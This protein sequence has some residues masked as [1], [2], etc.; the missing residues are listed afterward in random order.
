MTDLYRWQEEALDAL[1]QTMGAGG[2]GATI[3][4]VTGAGKTRVA[5][6]FARRL[7]MQAREEEG[8]PWF[9]TVVVPRKS[10]MLQWRDDLHDMFNRSRF[11]GRFGGGGI[12]GWD[13]KPKPFWNI[14][15]INAMRDGKASEWLS[16]IKE[17]RNHL[18][19]VD[20][21]HNITAPKNRKALDPEN[22]HQTFV[23]GMSATPNANNQDEARVQDL[24]GPIVYSYR[25]NQALIDEVIPPFVVKATAIPLTADETAEQE[26]LTKKVRSV[27]NDLRRENRDGFR[28]NQLENIQRALYL[29]RKRKLNGCRSRLSAA[30][31]ILNGHPRVPTMV[32]HDTIEAV[33]DLARKTQQLN[34]L[35]YH[36]GLSAKEGNAVLKA[37]ADGESDFLYSCKALTEGFN[38]PRVERAIMMSGPNKPLQRIQTL[39]RCL[40]GKT[41]TPNE[42]YF[43]YVPNT[44]DVKGLRN[45][46]AEADIPSEVFHYQYF[47]PNY[48]GLSNCSQP[49]WLFGTP[50][51]PY[52]VG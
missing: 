19:I 52:T 18:V 51:G 1:G 4:A 29:K 17:H 2:S 16:R 46:M 10:L 30:L 13:N 41:D 9:V 47:N 25:Y 49:P 33:E 37:F 38:V 3:A 12:K 15:T 23:L 50:S 42:I 28:R 48:T 45:L 21:C 43:L 32:F 39:G 31:R 24:C 6:E 11:V 36:S 14:A 40:R 7:V 34:P 20:E 22:A 44:T 5:L 8:D 35:V 27:N 26:D